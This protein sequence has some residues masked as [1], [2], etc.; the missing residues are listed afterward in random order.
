MR[1]RIKTHIKGMPRWKKGLWIGLI[2]APPCLI[3]GLEAWLFSMHGTCGLVLVNHQIHYLFIILLVYGLAVPLIAF[4]DVWIQ[5]R[6]QAGRIKLPSLYVLIIAIVGIVISIALFGLLLGM[7]PCHRVG[8]KSPQLLMAD[9]SGANGIP[10][11]A[12]CFWTLDPSQNILCWGT[13][14]EQ[15]TI[16]E[17]GPSQQHAFNLSDLHPDTEYW[18]RINQ[19]E[20]SRFTTP[21]PA[22]EPLHFA[23]GSDSHVG[24]SVSRTDLTVKMLRQIADPEYDY[25]AFFFLGDFVDLG[26]LDNLWQEAIEIFS[27]ATSII[28]GRPIIGNHDTLF[29]GLKLYE[30]YLY[31]DGMKLDIGTSMYYRIDFNDIHFLLLDL[32]WSAE[33]YTAEQDRWLEQQLAGIPPEDW[34]IVM[35]HG[36]Y[37][38]SGAVGYGWDWW[39]NQST[40]KRIT[41]LFEKYDVDIVV[42]GHNHVLEVL[43]KSGVT[44]LICGAFGGPPEPE[45]TYTS[46]QSIWYQRGVYAFLDVTI[47]ADKATIIFRN[48]DYNE[49]ESFTITP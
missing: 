24:N 5:S 37:Y 33:S 16:K 19:G 40:I 44:Y 25:D 14:D 43:Q 13:E 17:Q 9:G 34:T 47:N 1:D 8:D 7:G 22:G 15:F 36:Y 31:P 20:I 42:S 18:Y 46:P 2:A 28:P 30:E 38:S 32:E 48:S 11:M 27:P 3:L 29:G 12:V 4:L 45:R 23:V 49:I 41:P 10:D 26:F 21:P 35:S 39:D 6:R